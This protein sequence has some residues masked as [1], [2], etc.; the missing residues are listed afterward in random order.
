MKVPG[1]T[2]TW[3]QRN[4]QLY[5]KLGSP[6]GAYVA[7][8]RQNE[9]LLNQV[10]NNNYYISGL[11]GATTSAASA[12]TNPGTAAGNTAPGAGGTSFGDI[13]SYED[14]FSPELAKSAAAQRSARYYDP[15]VDE[16]QRTTL[17]GFA[18]RNLGRSGMRGRDLLKMYQ[19]YADQETQMREKLFG[20]RE[21]EAL[22]GYNAERSK[23]EENTQGYV[24][25]TT[26]AQTGYE[27]QFPEESPHKYSKSYRDWLREA[28]KI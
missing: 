8:G 26:S 12:T 4:R 20:E 24:K 13:L 10:H 15:L 27:Y 14:Y 11:P 2:G 17:S 21:K 22:E 1:L 5:E 19:D 25:P 28:Y 23:W 3:Q 18:G 16:S 7:D 6:L 9:W